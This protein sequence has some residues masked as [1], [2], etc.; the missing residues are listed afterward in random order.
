MR[1]LE[2]FEQKKDYAMFCPVYE[3]N[4]PTREPLKQVMTPATRW[5]SPKMGPPLG[6]R[7]NFRNMIC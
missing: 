2:H 1:K 7:C 3:L 5:M 6:P 4:V